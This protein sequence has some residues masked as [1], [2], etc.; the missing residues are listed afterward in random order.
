M[1]NLSIMEDASVGV[2]QR[3]S[4]TFD[5]IVITNLSD[6]LISKEYRAQNLKKHYG[7][8]FSDIICLLPFSD[9]ASAIAQIA[10][11]RDVR[12]FVDD[13]LSHVKEGESVGVVSY[14]Y[15]Y[16]MICGRNTGEVSEVDSWR[17]IELLLKNNKKPF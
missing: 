9:K 6:N 2:L 4:K 10:R 13:C 1:A 15:T 14:Q 16:N 12:L 3:L 5:I 11:K 7:D 17:G 8:I